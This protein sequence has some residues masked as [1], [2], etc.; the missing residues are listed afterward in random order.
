M[1][2][3]QYVLIFQIVWLWVLVSVLR[4]ELFCLTRTPSLSVQNYPLPLCTPPV[5][6]RYMMALQIRFESKR[7]VTKALCQASQQLCSVPL[8]VKYLQC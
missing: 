7:K 4:V 2:C 3:S 5:C 8:E 6:A 1:I